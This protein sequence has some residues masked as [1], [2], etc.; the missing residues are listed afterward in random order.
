M[1]DLQV[2]NI[3]RIMTANH[4]LNLE[5]ICYS[6]DNSVL[7][8]GRPEMVV[9]RMSN[10]CNL[11]MFR[12]G[13]VQIF[14]NLKQE[15]AEEMR[16]EFV[17]KLRTILPNLQVTPLKIVNLVVSVMLKHAIPLRTI[18][19]SN[20]SVFYE[21]ELF[22]AALIRKWHPAHIAVFHNGKVIITGVKTVRD[23][24]TLISELSPFL[25]HL[26]TSSVKK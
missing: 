5:L 11:Q 14:G 23:V 10:G 15:E 21:A 26:Q 18:T 8:R 25:T 2:I 4:L 22:P 24:Y 1:D 3:V 17:M 12:G 13:K 20:S 19:S 16:R 9:M 6:F 7:H